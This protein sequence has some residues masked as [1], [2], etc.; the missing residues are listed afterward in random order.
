MNYK[1]G[2]KICGA[3][4]ALLL[5]FNL[6]LSACSETQ[7]P[8]KA[9]PIGA[10]ALPSVQITTS[11][12][13]TIAGTTASNIINATSTP[14]VIA[15]DTTSASNSA[16]TTASETTTA[17]SPTTTE[18]AT[19]TTAT[20]TNSTTP[21][22]VAPTP[23][24]EG[25]AVKVD[26][27]YELKLIK[28]AYDAVL[29]HLFKAPDTAAI[30]TAAL[31]EAANVTQQNVPSVNFSDNSAENWNTFTTAFNKIVDNAAT[32]SSFTYPK[33]QLAHRTV[34]AMADAVKDE[35]TAFLNKDDY[36]SRNNLLQGDNTSIG[37]GI[38]FTTGETNELYIVRVVPGS[39]ADKAGLKAGDQIVKFDD[40]IANP[41]SRTTI[42]ASLQG[43][44]HTFVVKRPGQSQTLT[45]RATK[46]EYTMPTVEYRMIN[47]TIGYIAI[48][49]FFTNVASETDKAMRDLYKQGAKGWIIDVRDNPGGVNAEEIVGRFVKGGEIMGYNNNRKQHQ[50]DKVSNDG[51]SGAD[52]GKPFAPLLPLVLLV[53]EGSA[54]SSEILALAIRD[55]KL[56]TII[57][58]KTSGA[59]G[60]TA[61]YSLGDDTA[62]TVTVDEYVAVKGERDNGVG[63]SPDITVAITPDD[64]ANNR[65]P[66]LVAAVSEIQKNMSKP[67]AGS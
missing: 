25:A 39:G 67:A 28:A 23:T 30:L 40:G 65:D 24:L 64:Y 31:S 46:G 61:A 32:A 13:T 29:A 37:F 2:K 16:A 66:Q 57:G 41:K 12:D 49:D 1:F 51:L 59:L 45:I 56:G 22:T 55:F 14:V 48:R 62:I 17:P 18:A 44:T 26:K 5:A 8:L 34:T 43:S 54:S 63:V 58:Q 15:T 35:H 9:T 27:D 60:H 38:V 36:K 20:K 19:N 47:N 6:L 4:A 53:D 52:N 21:T 11:T 50:E 33:G 3:L 10:V 7:V 42:R